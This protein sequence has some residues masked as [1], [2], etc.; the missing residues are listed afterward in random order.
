MM[1]RTRH[2]ALTLTMILSLHYILSFSYE[3]YGRATSFNAL[4]AQL[5]KGGPRPKNAVKVFH[6]PPYKTPVPDK[7]Y[8]QDKGN[9]TFEGPDGGAAR[10]CAR[11]NDLDGVERS[12]RQLE[13]KW[14]S[15]FKYPY[16]I[17]NE[18][19]EPFSRHFI[20]KI[21]DIT[22]SQIS[23]GVIPRNH[24]YQPA[25]IDE[26]RAG[27]SRKDMEKNGIIYGGSLPHR[28]MYRFNSGFFRHPLLSQYQYYWRVEPDVE[29]FC[30]L[31]YDPF[32]F[33]QDEGKKYGFTISTY[34][35]ERT[36][37]TLWETVKERCRCG[38]DGLRREGFG[39]ALAG[40][41]RARGNPHRRGWEEAASHFGVDR[42]LRQPFGRRLPKSATG[43]GVDR[44]VSH[45][46]LSL[47]LLAE[48][49][50]RGRSPLV[51]G[52]RS[53]T[54]RRRRFGRVSH[55]H[56]SEGACRCAD[57]R[58]LVFVRGVFAELGALAGDGAN[59]D[60]GAYSLR[61]R[62]DMQT[63][64]G[65][66]LRAGAFAAVASA[67]VSLLGSVSVRRRARACLFRVSV[68]AGRRMGI[69]DAGHLTQ[70]GLRSAGVWCCAQ[71]W[72]TE[73]PPALWRH[74]T[75]TASCVACLRDDDRWDMVLD[76]VLRATL[77]GRGAA[78]PLPSVLNTQGGR[79]R[80][81]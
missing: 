13:E 63:C 27:A 30:H 79:R 77:A 26:A 12:M 7:Y 41:F 17:L 2:V 76:A 67:P 35:F 69:E 52:R 48:E 50:R 61:P 1:T 4:L 51:W 39:R 25:F 80:Y 72:R 21:A 56:T 74:F 14:N 38:D 23:F 46:T 59:A 53:A 34:K 20:N 49:G 47:G 73:M 44:A 45:P 19:L 70:S 10:E 18:D 31:D 3:D 75:T 60:L 32:L 55:S 81:S 16:V 6:K 28:N 57:V 43:G 33:M 9:G 71:C 62:V 5:R 24:W 58:G 68:H 15:K 22:P 11:N 65:L 78:L 40:R 37:P 66:S 64:A 29:F 8:L 36:I 42:V 54:W